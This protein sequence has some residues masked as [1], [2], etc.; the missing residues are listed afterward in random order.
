MYEAAAALL[1]LGKPA[2]ALTTAEVAA[3]S[4]VVFFATLVIVRVADRR[5]MARLSAFDVVLG[6][7][8]A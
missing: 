5:F 8:L 3:R 4:V 6:L 2:D 1:G 7:I